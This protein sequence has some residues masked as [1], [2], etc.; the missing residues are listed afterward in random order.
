[1]AYQKLI[2]VGMQSYKNKLKVQFCCD[3]PQLKS[4]N[5]L[6]QELCIPGLASLLAVVMNLFLR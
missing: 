4:K 3:F 5:N 6:K 2:W 1:M